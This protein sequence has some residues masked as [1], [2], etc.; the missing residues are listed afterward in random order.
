MNN[1]KTTRTSRFDKNLWLPVLKTWLFFLA[2]MCAMLLIAWGVSVYQAEAADIS[3]G[4]IQRE[5]AFQLLHG[6]EGPIGS[7]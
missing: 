5:V 6:I 7:I 2:L 3:S 1:L 4:D